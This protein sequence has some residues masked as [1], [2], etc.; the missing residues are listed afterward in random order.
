[1]EKLIQIRKEYEKKINSLQ[2]LKEY[3][4]IEKTVITGA[5]S[6]FDKF[7]YLSQQEKEFFIALHLDSKNFIK[8]HEII[9][10]GTLDATIVH[11]REIFKS[12]ILQSSSR[13]ILIHN[14]PSGDPTPSQEDLNMT[15][16][17]IDVGELIGIEILD[18]VIIG[19]D[20]FWSHVEG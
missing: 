11:P 2:F 6:V 1:M 12:A 8:S 17:L 9:S 20:K 14:H 4:G 5:K 7:K 18:H 10:V 13:I 3:S 16:K 19:K 15:R